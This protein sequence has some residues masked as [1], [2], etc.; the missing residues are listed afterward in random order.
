MANRVII[1]VETD[2]FCLYFQNVFH[3]MPTRHAET[4]EPVVYC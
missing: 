4:N 2:V 1:S 3:M